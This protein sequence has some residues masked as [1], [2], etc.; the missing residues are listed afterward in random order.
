MHAILYEKDGGFRLESLHNYSQ[1]EIMNNIESGS[2]YYILVGGYV[3][4]SHNAIPPSRFYDFLITG[5][6]YIF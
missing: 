2:R 6:I 4:V 5:Q 3:T 1:D